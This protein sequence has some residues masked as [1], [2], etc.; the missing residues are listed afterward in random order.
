MHAI[1][2][3]IEKR[4]ACKKETSPQPV[5]SSTTSEDEL[6]RLVFI[7]G[8]SLREDSLKKDSLRE[9]LSE[10]K[11]EEDLFDTVKVGIQKLEVEPCSPN[12]SKLETAEENR[13]LK[14]R[15]KASSAAV[16]QHSNAGLLPS[17]QK[18]EEPDESIS[19]K[20]STT[21]VQEYEHPSISLK[22]DPGVLPIGLL[23]KQAPV[24]NT[25]K[26][27]HFQRSI[28]AP[29]IDVSDKQ[30]EVE[31]KSRYVTTKHDS[32][33]D[34]LTQKVRKSPP[35]PD[36][37]YE[38]IF[39]RSVEEERDRETPKPQTDQ[40][41][42]ITTDLQAFSRHHNE[43]K[44]SP[45]A[46]STLPECLIEEI[47]RPQIH[48]IYY[49][50][51][52]SN[53]E[54]TEEED[55]QRLLEEVF[56]HPPPFSKTLP[57]EQKRGFQRS[58]DDHQPTKGFDVFLLGQNEEVDDKRRTGPTLSDELI[59]EIFGPMNRESEI[60]ELRGF[61][62]EGSKEDNGLLYSIST[63]DQVII[64]DY[65]SKLFTERNAE[66]DDS[67][68]KEEDFKAEEKKEP[69]RFG[70]STAEEKLPRVQK[71]VRIVE[72]EQR[73]STSIKSR[74]QPEDPE[75]MEV[76]E[77]IGN[78]E[79][80]G[81]PIEKGSIEAGFIEEGST[82]AE[83]IEEDTKHQEVKEPGE[84]AKTFEEEDTGKVYNDLN[85]SHSIR[86]PPPLFTDFSFIEELV[87][88][89]I[90]RRQRQQYRPEIEQCRLSMVEEVS[91][92][93]TTPKGSTGSPI[94]RRSLRGSIK[95]K[96]SPHYSYSTNKANLT[97]YEE[98]SIK[99]SKS[100]EERMMM[101]DDDDET[102]QQKPKKGE[103]VEQLSSAMKP[104]HIDVN[105]ASL[106]RS[107]LIRD[108]LD[109]PKQHEMNDSGIGMDVNSSNEFLTS[110][111][112]LLQSSHRSTPQ[113]LNQPIFTAEELEDLI[114]KPLDKLSKVKEEKESVNRPRFESLFQEQP[115]KSSKHV[116]KDAPV[117]T[118]PIYSEDA[119]WRMLGYVQGEQERQKKPL[120]GV[121]R[122]ILKKKR[123][124]ENSSG[125]ESQADDSPEGRSTSS[126]FDDSLP[127]TSR[128]SIDLAVRIRSMPPSPLT[129]PSWNDRPTTSPQIDSRP[130]VRAYQHQKLPNKQSSSLI[131]I[132]DSYNKSV[133][134]DTSKTDDSKDPEFQGT[135]LFPKV[136]IVSHH[137]YKKFNTELSRSE[138]PLLSNVTQVHHTLCMKRRP[139]SASPHANRKVILE[140]TDI[141]EIVY[142][143]NDS[144]S[145]IEGPELVK[146]KVSTR[147]NS[148]STPELLNLLVFDSEREPKDEKAE[149]YVEFRRYRSRESDQIQSKTKMLKLH[150]HRDS[151]DS[152]STEGSA[153][154]FERTES[155]RI[156][157]GIQTSAGSCRKMPG[158]SPS[159]SY[160]KTPSDP[161]RLYI[162][163]SSTIP[164]ASPANSGNFR[165]LI[166][167]FL[168]RGKNL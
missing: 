121:Q 136:R 54:N 88:E 145:E 4:T 25:T 10:F 150:V 92:T 97:T 165:R 6:M 11:N 44:T 107:A 158:S 134:N 90:L 24:M 40:D 120:K 161:R 49:I 132:I 124:S 56:N 34:E 130:K 155:G 104:L 43:I 31:E 147:V 3:V 86:S 101:V 78:L 69:L 83:F 84:G 108:Q 154:D 80:Y 26:L 163:R 159:H 23:H 119:I 62:P 29:S 151:T 91:E 22:C 12:A 36:D 138:D 32:G 27:Q 135:A 87:N 57:N 167:S 45:V 168:F 60:K 157:R 103:D 140:H 73:K 152:A 35:I 17:T 66:R 2:L 65:Y 53:L 19:R 131:N 115:H 20:K 114:C 39:E 51:S 144:L 117:Q 7:E 123:F 148:L 85:D 68:V 99:E 67:E 125:G 110:D 122:Q 74:Y 118:P 41:S 37:I 102:Q 160:K 94:S 79:K 47:F 113:L 127:E 28:T 162:V 82:E 15:E 55:Q 58:E 5:S 141:T 18:F 96:D 48:S 111:F 70:D 8:N 61:E 156:Q 21:K 164:R 98:G 59:E 116:K 126:I 14:V 42:N 129:S 139:K 9:K 81:K 72:V 77:D 30:E 100:E 71:H 89:S 38:K 63:D 46:G 146:T 149:R 52:P 1:L 112:P 109:E 128:S 64:D 106:Q 13:L 142:G 137:R 143:D 153:P 133:S 16:Q 33:I 75:Y 95:D 166:I 93:S 76:L 50:Q 105:T